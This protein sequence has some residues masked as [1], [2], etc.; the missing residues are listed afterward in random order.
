MQLNIKK[1][2]SQSKKRG[3]A[4]DLNRYSSKEDTQIAR[5][6]MKRCSATLIV[7]EIQIKATMRYHPTPSRMAII[8]TLQTISAREDVDKMEHF[9]TAGGNTNQYSNNGEQYGGSFKN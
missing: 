8:K 3:G 1:Q 7:R 9:Y 6:D 2:I 4:E 5:K